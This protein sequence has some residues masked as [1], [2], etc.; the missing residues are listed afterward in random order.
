VPLLPGR[1][2]PDEDVERADAVAAPERVEPDPSDRRSVDLD[3]VRVPFLAS[4]LLARDDVLHGE[5]PFVVHQ[6]PDL[7]VVLPGVDQRVVARLHRPKEHADAVDHAAV[8]TRS[9]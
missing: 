6:P 2:F 8:S 7:R 4:T 3:H 9:R 1:T 5:R